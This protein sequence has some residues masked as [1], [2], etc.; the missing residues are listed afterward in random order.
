MLVRAWSD[1]AALYA[2]GTPQAGLELVL[3]DKEASLWRVSA[4]V[5]PMYVDTMS[6]LLPRQRDQERSW[7]LMETRAQWRIMNPGPTSVAAT[8]RLE[9]SAFG[10][11]RI[12][13]VALDGALVQRVSMSPGRD[14]YV[15]GPLLVP[16]GHHALTFTVAEPNVTI[17]FGGWR[18]TTIPEV[19]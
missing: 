11:D 12:M 10:R 14:V 9:L 3:R 13:D 6:G 5:P 19:R 7:R 18:W 15:I 2:P 8:L 16:R 17:A 1:D 4:R